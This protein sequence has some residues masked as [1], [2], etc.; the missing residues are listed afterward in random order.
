MICEFTKLQT[1]QET[2]LP[3]PYF[4]AGSQDSIPNVSDIMG[5]NTLEAA[6]VGGSMQYALGDTSTLTGFIM[7]TQHSPPQGPG[8]CMAEEL[9]EAMQS[10]P[11]F[12]S[13]LQQT[14]ASACAVNEKLGLP[15]PSPNILM[16]IAEEGVGA[17]SP[18]RESHD[19]DIQTPHSTS[20]AEPAK[21]PAK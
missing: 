11:S 20:P 18:V 21:S 2:S 10:E 14:M 1:P 17:V 5:N 13:D 15:Q 3:I 6:L 12:A 16:N 8:N 19:A 7:S 9:M 4:D